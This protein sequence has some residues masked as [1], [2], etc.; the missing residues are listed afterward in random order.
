MLYAKKLGIQKVLSQE[1]L[2]ESKALE[3]KK[4]QDQGKRDDNFEEMA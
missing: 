1:C 3:I 2:P 4:L